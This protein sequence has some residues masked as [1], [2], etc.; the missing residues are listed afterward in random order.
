MAM[1]TTEQILYDGAR[2]LVMEFTG[3]HDG[4]GGQET[5]VV[6]VDVSALVPPARLVSIRSIEYDV[7]GGT[8]KLLWGHA[9][10]PVEFLLLSTA[11]ILSYHRISG[12]PN[13]A[14]P[15]ATGD[16]LL[17]TIGFGNGS[18]YS[19]KLEMLKKL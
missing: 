13:G 18:A 6:K 5:E 9:T 2:N 15:D 8:V 4:A 10:S 19:L 12:L 3:R 11:N 14:G 17:S 16:I 1:T 7:S